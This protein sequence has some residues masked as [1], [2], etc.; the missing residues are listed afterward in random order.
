[1]RLHG[2]THLKELNAWFIL[3]K[4]KENVYFSQ[5]FYPYK[6]EHFLFLQLVEFGKTPV[7]S[8]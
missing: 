5:H 6:G 7:L 3:S 4:T 2:E 1:M 8:L